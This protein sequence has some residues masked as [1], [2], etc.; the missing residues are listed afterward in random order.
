MGM[1]ELE[2]G[3]IR[4]DLGLVILHESKLTEDVVKAL[5]IENAEYLQLQEKTSDFAKPKQIR[6][7]EQLNIK[8]SRKQ[9]LPIV[10]KVLN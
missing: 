10:Q 6:I 9:I 7:F 4:R 8:A 1:K 2:S 5:S 3:G